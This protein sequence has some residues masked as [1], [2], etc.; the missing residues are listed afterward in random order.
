MEMNIFFFVTQIDKIWEKKSNANKIK[1][2]NPILS[3]KEGG[4][5]EMKSDIFGRM[6]KNDS[7][8][9]EL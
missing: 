8:L 2:H 6:G 9:K 3:D 4:G 7:I 1:S 5:C